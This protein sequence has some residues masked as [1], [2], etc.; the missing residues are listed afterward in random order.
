MPKLKEGE[1]LTEEQKTLI[2]KQQMEELRNKEFYRLL[3]EAPKL[4]FNVNVFK[5]NCT[6]A[7]SKNE[8]E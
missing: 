2:A 7:A 3:K 1:Q 4:A 5:T 8:I 6:L